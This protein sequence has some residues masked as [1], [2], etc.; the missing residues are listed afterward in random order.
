[1]GPLH[2]AT[3]AD[4]DNDGSPELLALETAILAAEAEIDS[5]LGSRYQLPLSEPIP[6]ILA[7]VTLDLTLYH[8]AKVVPALLN[9]AVQE[10]YKHR[11]RWLE[12]VV[13]GKVGLGVPVASIP[14]SING[15]VVRY[16]PPRV[17]QRKH[18][19]CLF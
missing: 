18:T 4:Q 6:P 15:G 9:E 8:L 2:L 16:G 3:Y 12:R 14:D 11:I 19:K 1:V 13:D 17:M 5:Y 10:A 7:E